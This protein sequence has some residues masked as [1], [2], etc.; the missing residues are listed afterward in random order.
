MSSIIDS[1]LYFI[2][3]IGYPGIFFVMFLEGLSIPFPGAYFIIFAGFLVAGGLLSFWPTLLAGVLGFTLGSMGPFIM[4][5]LWGKNLLARI[6]KIS[7]SYHRKILLGQEW[8]E[9]Y[10]P[11]VVV[12]S[13]PLFCGKY[14]SYLAGIAKMYPTR[15]FCY[16]LMGAYLWCGG[17]LIL[18]VIFKSNLQQ[19]VTYSSMVLPGVLIL[20]I[21]YYISIRIYYRVK[22][23][24]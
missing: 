23:V 2:V 10:G 8:I 20:G 9:K 15:Y 6:E 14:V 11:M 7:N 19:V 24:G 21:V 13:R 1:I 22:G 12:F 18:G 17:L 3:L 4:S 16:T 5:F